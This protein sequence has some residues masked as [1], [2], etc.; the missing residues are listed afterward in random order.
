MQN[1]NNMRKLL[2]M[3]CVCLF[4]L[5]SSCSVNEEPILD[6]SDLG[7]V[8]SNDR[9]S[10]TDNC[11]NIKDKYLGNYKVKTDVRSANVSFLKTFKAT[12]NSNEVLKENLAVEFIGIYPQ[13][14]DFQIT[15]KYNQIT[16][17][18]SAYDIKSKTYTTAFFYEDHFYFFPRFIV[19]GTLDL[20]E[21]QLAGVLNI[22]AFDLYDN[23]SLIFSTS[24]VVR[25]TKDK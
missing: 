12:I 21:G 25:M 17:D 13:T 15:A 16:F 7:L 10:H 14:L 4:A 19:D 24:C 5:F 6:C 2:W 1:Y 9:I 3:V 20:T 11:I 22:A 23:N 18:N 8:D